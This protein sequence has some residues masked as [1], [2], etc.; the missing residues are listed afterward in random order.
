MMTNQYW[1]LTTI[2]H[3]WLSSQGVAYTLEGLVRN[4]STATW[5]RAMTWRM[6]SYTRDWDLDLGDLE[7]SGGFRFH[8]IIFPC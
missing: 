4:P 1:P 5:P 7:S 2:H 3:S 8:G 6:E